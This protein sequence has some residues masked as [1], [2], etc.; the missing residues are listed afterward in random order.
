MEWPQTVIDDLARR[1]VILVMG[2]GVSRHGLGVDGTTRPPIW[3]NFL[4]DGLSEL[5]TGDDCSHITAAINS[6]DYLHAC[7]WLKRKYYEN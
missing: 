3:K 4:L 2:S 6:G 1:R 5:V 7:E